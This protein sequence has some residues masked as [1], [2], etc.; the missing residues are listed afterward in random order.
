[1]IAKAI[2]RSIM[3]EKGIGVAKMAE[4]LKFKNLQT[5]SDRLGTGKSLNLSSDKLDEMV[6]VLGYKVVVVPDDVEMQDCWYEITDSRKEAPTQV[7][8]EE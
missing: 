5:V 7:S 2:V 8:G 3:N 6:R 1:M 4:M